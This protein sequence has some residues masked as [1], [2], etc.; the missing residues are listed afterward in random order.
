MPGR[1]AAAKRSKKG[2]V[3]RGGILV[4][5][6][7]RPVTDAGGRPVFAAPDGTLVLDDNG[8][9]PLGAVTATGTNNPPA[10]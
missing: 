9:P 10:S 7:G 4:D 2:D 5:D 1:K 6:G 3:R 8:T